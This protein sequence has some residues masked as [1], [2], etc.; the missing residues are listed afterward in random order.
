MAI[1]YISFNTGK[2]EELL[3]RSGLS[4]NA[5]YFTDEGLV[6]KGNL[7]MSV[8]KVFN[9]IYDAGFIN[10]TSKGDSSNSE[11][12]IVTDSNG[13]IVNTLKE[14]KIAPSLKDY[15][16]SKINADN[17]FYHITSA[18]VNLS[19]KRNI[20]FILSDYAF[21]ISTIIKSGIYYIDRNEDGSVYFLMPLNI[22]TNG[23]EFSMN[24]ID[25]NA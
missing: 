7:L 6:Y 1:D 12:N 21:N 25:Y 8:V 16:F 11:I 10:S 19:I 13:T 17:P 24:I 23:S 4:P 18:K 14:G 22:G 3:N 2:I 20:L 15:D 5:L 9:T